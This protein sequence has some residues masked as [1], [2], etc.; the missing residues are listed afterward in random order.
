M[1]PIKIYTQPEIEVTIG[2]DQ[3]VV[4]VNQ[5]GT[6]IELTVGG[7]FVAWGDIVGAIQDQTDLQNALDAKVDE[8]SPITGAT[9]TKITYDSK[10]LVTAG[11][12]AGIS[13]I[14]GL[15]TALDLKV[16]YTGAT[17]NVTL[18]EYGLTTGYIQFDTTPTTYTPAIGNMGWN[19]VEG[20]IDLLLRGGVV[21]LPIGQKQVARIVNGTGIN[22]LKSNYQV[23]KV[24]GAQGQRLQ[25]NLAQ[26]NNDANSADTLGLIAEN[27]NNNNTGFIVTSGLLENINT[28]GSLQGETWS[29][30]NVLYLSPTVPG[31]VTNIKPQ[32]P[33]HTVIIGFVIYA[34]PNNGKIYCKIDNGYEIDELHN[35]R[36]TS[37]TNGQV[38]KY[39]TSLSVWENATDTVGTGTV[40][41]VNATGGTGISVSGSPI[42]TSGTLTITNT[43][44]DQTVVLN[45]GTGISTSGTYP[46]FTITN[47]APDQTV[48][49]SAGTGI[50]TSGTYPNFT[51][52]NSAPDQ[53][54]S[55]TGGGTVTISG[56]YPNFTITGSASGLADGDKGDITVSSSGS[57]WTIDNQAVTYAKIQNVTDNRLLGRSSGSAGSVQE[58]TIGSGLSLSGGTLTNT[59]S[60]SAYSISTKTGN[61]T[62]TATSGEIILLGDTTSG[63]FTITLPTAISNTAKITIKKIAGSNNLTIDGNGSQTIDGGL[64]AD[65]VR[66]YESITL[67]SDNSNWHII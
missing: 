13:D 12:D 52:T 22:V 50:S 24:T 3:T 62:E 56:T 57:V 28:T 37:P 45:S 25:V 31:R 60:S 30:G 26:A 39:N 21:S 18:G 43:A 40:T 58:I 19:D 5:A 48:A 34:H 8:N 54:V 51:V 55:L 4:E 42:T 49:I 44:P 64:T 1:Q 16:P 67:V 32:A 6:P 7:T 15:Q 59:G 9:K 2:N 33:Q 66:V 61:Y 36:I 20:T 11:T 23:V 27:I 14:T 10:G 35:V 41:Q 65:L 38:L 46:N 17:D 53:T 29:D 47:S 63:T